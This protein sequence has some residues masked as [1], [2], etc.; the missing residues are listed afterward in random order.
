MALTT[1]EFSSEALARTARMNVLIPDGIASPCPVLYLHHGL[2]DTYTTFA[3]RTDLEQYVQQHNLIVVT[4][5]AGDSWFCND[6]RPGGLAWEEH[7]AVEVV[8]YMDANFPTIA[9]RE[10]RGLA[11]FSMGGYGAIMLGMKHPDRFS[12]ISTHAGS[13]AFGHALRPDRPERSAFMQAVA[14]P[15]GPY[16]LWQLAPRLAADGPDMAIRFDVGKGDHLLEINRRLHALL[17]E[18]GIKHEYEEVDGGHQ[19]AY[20]NR[21]LPVTLQYASEHLA[22]K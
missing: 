4:P 21:Q 3:Q 14:P 6:P 22:S 10:G 19:W 7:L 2:G 9:A 16:D 5:D 8:D 20:V 11:G 1:V 15:G 12:A 17:E 13:F 18:L